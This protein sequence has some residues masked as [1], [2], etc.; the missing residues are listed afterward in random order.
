MFIRNCP[1]YSGLGNNSRIRLIRQST[2]L[3]S[4]FPKRDRSAFFL[5]MSNF[6]RAAR[7]ISS[8]VGS[9]VPS[10]LAK[11]GGTT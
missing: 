10:V 4:K 3:T 11:T 2:H 5:K 1:A 7:A 6:E 8:T 9:P